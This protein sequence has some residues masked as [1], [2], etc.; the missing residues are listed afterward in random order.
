M[1]LGHSIEEDY[2]LAPGGRSSEL[3]DANAVYATFIFVTKDTHKQFSLSLVWT[4]SLPRTRSVDMRDKIAKPPPVKR[5]E[6][7]IKERECQGP[8]I[9]YPWNH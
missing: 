5:N 3:Q 7:D 2:G 6:C 8:H 1:K 4:R 9:C